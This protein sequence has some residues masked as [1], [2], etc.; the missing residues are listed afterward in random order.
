MA[1]TVHEPPRIEEIGDPS[2]PKSGSGN[3]GWRNLIPAG[4]L[5]TAQEYAP[6]PASTGISTAKLSGFGRD[7]KGEIYFSEYADGNVF[8][9]EKM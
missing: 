6:P 1:T 2:R 5:R 8:K 3:G 7:G 9:I 4:D